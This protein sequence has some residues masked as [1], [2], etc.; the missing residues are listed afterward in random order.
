MST[1]AR[2][3]VYQVSELNELLRALV[4]DSLPSLWVEGEIS[5]L[6]RPSSGH[7]YFSLK[8]SAAQIRC[9]MF[10]QHNYL[11]RPPPANGDRVRVRGRASVYPSRGELQLV[12][13][14][15]EAAGDGELFRAFAA[16]KA[17]LD[18]EGLFA[19]AR[20]RPLPPLPR[21]I[22]IITSATGAA[23]QDVRQALERRWP[24]AEALLY[25]VPV[26]GDASAP[27]LI[28]A[29][30]ELPQRAAV[31]LVLLVRGGGSIEDL[32]SFNE[33]TVARAIRDCTVPVVCGVGHEI[34][35][36]IADFAA[37]L[38][39]PTPT[40]AA[41]LATPDRQELLLRIA[42]LR[43]RLLRAHQGQLQTLKR[44]QLQLEE[45]LR[46]QHPG[47][48][49]Q[50]RAQRLDELEQ[51]LL[52]ACQATPLQRRQRLLGLI[53]RLLRAA[54]RDAEQTQHDQRLRSLQARLLNAQRRR[55]DQHRQQLQRLQS[56]LA[57][58]DAQRVLNRGYA[59]VFDDG[60]RLVRHSTEVA[61]GAA[62]RVRVADGEMRVR[63]A[64]D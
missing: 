24:L 9:A 3:T 31:D 17:R 30:A 25:P 2:R 19:P 52:R 61:A 57:S 39:A 53:E 35:F 34:D 40:A 50:D 16:L 38:R 49:L 62:L 41:E 4:E 44:H 56:L 64:A 1:L 46:R 26:Q 20:K 8:D 48:R 11:V 18:A 5:N 36:T 21:R 60:G 29:L 37:D 55:L 54:R 23:L 13:E 28:R 27:A 33:E 59:L 51:R 7:W 63:R 45:R 22:G 10:R 32:W 14:A 6:A 58:L 15:L 43:Q 42:G 12:V 47:R